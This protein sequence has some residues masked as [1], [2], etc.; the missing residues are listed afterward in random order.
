[1]QPEP[2]WES[3]PLPL[4]PLQCIDVPPHWE[5]DCYE[6]SHEDSTSR[7]SPAPETRKLQTYHLRTRA[8]PYANDLTR[9]IKPSY[10]VPFSNWKLPHAVCLAFTKRE[11]E[12][13]YGYWKDKLSGLELKELA[14]QKGRINNRIYAKKRRKELAALEKNIRAENKRLRQENETLREN[15]NEILHRVQEFERS[16]QKLTRSSEI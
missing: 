10:T 7:E 1:M 4:L 3:E 12:L 6:D 8:K 14:N 11:S 16:M 5:D 2:A 9:E 13:H 15:Y